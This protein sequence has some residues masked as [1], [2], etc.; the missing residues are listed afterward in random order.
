MEILQS[1]PL[2][3]LWLSLLGLGVGF[4]TGLFGIGGAFITTPVMITCFDLEP[5]T[6]VGCSMGF[7]LVNGA[8]GLRRH[9]G[10]GNFEPRAMWPIAIAACTGTFLGFLYHNELKAT[11]EDRFDT[12]VNGMFCVILVPIGL[13]VWW[14]S[15]KTKGKPWLSRVVVP[16]MVRLRQEDL[17]PVS[18]TLLAL[19]GLA[20]GIAKGLLGLGGGIILVPVLVLVVGMAPHRAVM[21]SLGMVVL[22]SVIGTALYAWQGDIDFLVVGAMLL[23]SLV[24]VVLGARFC[25]V[26]SPERLKRLLAI[27]ILLFSMYLGYLVL[28]EGEA[29]NSDEPEEVAARLV[30]DHVAG[31]RNDGQKLQTSN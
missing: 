12:V 25:N 8:L 28:N 22:S 13:L 31:D 15:N 21:T 24:G 2:L 19:V 3:L 26:T 11:F 1:E 30:M 17:P 14:Q 4:L 16:P 23:G 20:I 5:S 9:A 6:A 27:L 29:E 18:I 10:A 7:T